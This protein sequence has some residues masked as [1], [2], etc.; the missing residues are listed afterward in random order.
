MDR[1]EDCNMLLL[2]FA[3]YVVVRQASIQCLANDWKWFCTGGCSVETNSC[4]MF[5]TNFKSHYELL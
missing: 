2:S 4:E 1:S 3:S 5:F